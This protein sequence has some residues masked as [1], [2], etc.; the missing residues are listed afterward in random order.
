[1]VEAKHSITLQYRSR[2]SC[3]SINWFFCL[4]RNCVE[5]EL[6]MSQSSRLACCRRLWRWLSFSRK[7][8]ILFFFVDSISRNKS[9]FWVLLSFAR[10]ST[11]PIKDATRWWGSESQKKFVS[12][13]MFDAMDTDIGACFPILVVGLV[14]LKVSSW[15]QSDSK[16]NIVKFLMSFYSLVYLTPKKSSLCERVSRNWFRFLG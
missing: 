3:S 2:Y 1:M 15:T 13:R 10:P 5:A 4:Y 14:Y 11:D 9:A 12:L 7:L 6:S 16:S 8:P